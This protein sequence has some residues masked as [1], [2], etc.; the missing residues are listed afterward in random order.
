MKDLLPGKRKDI[1]ISKKR[2]VTILGK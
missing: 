1:R 2:Q